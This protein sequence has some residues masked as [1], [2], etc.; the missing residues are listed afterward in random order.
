MERTRQSGRAA[1]R[2]SSPTGRNRAPRAASN[3]L[4]L[5][6]VLE[7]IEPRVWR[8]IQVPAGYT[9]W[10]LHVAIQDAMGWENYHLHEFGAVD[11]VSREPLRIGIPD[12]EWPEERPMLAGWE[13][14]L[15]PHFPRVGTHVSYLYDFGDGWRHIVTFEGTQP[16]QDGESYPR[17]VDGARACPPEDVG[18][19]Y[20]Y[21]EFL[22]ALRDPRHDRHDELVEWSGGDFDPETF[23]PGHVRFDDPR[24]R[25]KAA[26]A[27]R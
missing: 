13:V 22:E 4:Q 6:I 11:P 17:C 12:D 8:R 9:F 19:P 5:A 14:P 2:P 27:S 15:A 1:R 16:R 10:E 24:R 3:V 18:G 25:W 20:G 26:F 21:A 23:V 7:E